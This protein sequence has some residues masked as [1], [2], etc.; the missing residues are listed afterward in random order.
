M[1]QFFLLNT[2]ITPV[3]NT[4]GS[5]LVLDKKIIYSVKVTETGEKHNIVYG[6]IGGFLDIL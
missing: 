2:L 6:I 1:E 3:V 4:A 5:I